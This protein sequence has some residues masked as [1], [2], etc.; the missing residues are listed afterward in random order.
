MGGVTQR[1]L[2]R[3][4]RTAI[5]ALGENSDLDPAMDDATLQ[6]WVRTNALSQYHMA[7]TCKLG[8]DE[9]AVVDPTLRVFGVDGLRVVD[10]SVLPRVVSSHCQAAIMAIAERAAGLI[11]DTHKLRLAGASASTGV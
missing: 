5:G 7:G 4:L 6:G 2:A 9:Q 8:L 1:I 11:A 3:A 10:A